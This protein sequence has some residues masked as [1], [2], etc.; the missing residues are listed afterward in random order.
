LS[1]ESNTVVRLIN[2]WSRLLQAFDVF[3]SL[4]D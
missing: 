1:N 2:G 3:F 4:A